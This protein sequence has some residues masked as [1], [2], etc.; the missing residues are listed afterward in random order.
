VRFESSF[1]VSLWSPKEYSMRNT[2]GGRMRWVMMSS[3]KNRTTM[4]SNQWSHVYAID[5][6]EWDFKPSK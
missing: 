2:N 6:K 1:D 3:K 4:S 5:E